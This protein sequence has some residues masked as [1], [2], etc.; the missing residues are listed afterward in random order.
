MVAIDGEFAIFYADYAKIFGFTLFILK[1]HFSTNA[2]EFFRYVL[3]VV[4]ECEV[5]LMWA[6]TF[7]Y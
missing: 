4:G 2:L 5:W 6:K 7:L 3:Q 1:F